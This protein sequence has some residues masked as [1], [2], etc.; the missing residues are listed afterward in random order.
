MSIVPV[1]MMPSGAFVLPQMSVVEP[2]A[3][4]VYRLTAVLIWPAVLGQARSIW[5]QLVTLG[6]NEN[7]AYRVGPKYKPVPL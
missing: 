1:A 5:Y 6:V 4:P 2:T 7:W 3:A